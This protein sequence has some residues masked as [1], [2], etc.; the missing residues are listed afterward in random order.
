MLIKHLSILAIAATAGLFSTM[1][2]E[3]SPRFTVTN[4]ADKMV[5]VF[6]FNGDDSGCH[7]E[8]KVKTIDSG[9]SNTIGCSGN[10]KGRC[11]I[12]LQQH[13]EQI[14]KSQFNTCGNKATKINNGDTVTTSQ[15]GEKVRCTFT[16]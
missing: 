14:C 3:A 12:F 13:G 16:N 6:V 11:K 9:H 4:N 5:K 15:D 1:S 7:L 2:A 10:G 8:E